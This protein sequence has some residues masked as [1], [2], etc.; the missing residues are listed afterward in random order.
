MAADPLL[1]AGEPPRIWTEPVSGPSDGTLA[2]RSRR[3]EAAAPIAPDA[4]S[5]VRVTVLEFVDGVRDLVV[6]ARADMVGR[7]RLDRIA[8]VLSGGVAPSDAVSEQPRDRLAKAPA[9]HGEWS[10]LALVPDAPGPW[11]A[12]DLAAALTLVLARTLRDGLTDVDESTT[13]A[14]FRALH[15]G[16]AQDGGEIADRATVALLVDPDLPPASLLHHRPAL[17]ADHPFTL[18]AQPDGDGAYSLRLW[19]RAGDLSRAERLASLLTSALRALTEPDQERSLGTVELLDGA[20]AS[21]VLALGGT[22]P[23]RPADRLAIPELVRARALQS[24]DAIAVVDRSA[25][26]TYRELVDRADELALGLDR[27]GVRPGDRVGVCL[28]RSAELVVALLAVMTAGAAYVPLDPAH[29]AERLAFT[30]RDAGLDVVLTDGAAGDEALASCTAV[31]PGGL[32]AEGGNAAREEAQTAAVAP[33]GEPR[34][35]PSADDPAYVIYTSGSTGRPKGVVVPHRNVVAL[36]NATTDSFALGP[37]DV[38]TWFH[39]AAFDF[40]VWEI[41]GALTTGGR[42]VVVPYWTCR[43]P[44]DFRD[45]LARER[46]TVLN[47]TPSSFAG[48]VGLEEGRRPALD[49]LRLVILGG[50]P[51]DTGRLLP[52]FDA[53]P[54]SECRVVNMFGITETTVHVTGGTVTRQ[55][56]LSGDRSVGRPLPGWSV[57]ILDAS[58]R[59]LPPG[60]AGEIAVSGE[61]LALGY[62]NRP[63]LTAERFVTDPRDGTRLYLSGD[64]GLLRPDG[65]LEHHGRIDSQVQLRGHRIELDEIRHVLLGHED[66]REAVVRVV[67]PEDDADAA[68][69]EAY[70]VLDKGDPRRIRRHAARRLPE[71]MVPLVFDVPRIPL[72]VNGKTDVRRLTDM[73]AQAMADLRSEVGAAAPD[74]QDEDV[75][76][77]GANGGTE[78]LVLASWREVLA[79]GAEPDEDFFDLGGNSLLAL[80]V[81]HALRDKGLTVTVKDVYQ[82]RTAT[83]LAARIT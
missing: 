66:V 54:E 46:V 17:S 74:I 69:I 29:P 34:T 1:F 28:E 51:L 79:P 41:W 3:R 43:S 37:D 39:S 6:T 20:A 15:A 22:R 55:Q 61:G 64:V 16:E 38:W 18:H 67:R 10:D 26:L 68:R 78:E 70:V 81:C 76:L 40:S 83:A 35:V 57:R 72:T 44:E 25:G 13:V 50:E 60:S 48:L 53:Y 14:R 32:L 42:L 4:R 80:R 11:T 45:L 24:P 82:C 12:G 19:Y 27:L 73:A 8:T 52:W 30:V 47:Q 9:V 33:F 77:P 5:A 49:C 21:R 31:S 58:G 63:E 75:P 59:L 62:L 65:Q 71:Y 56:A 2:D 7:R 23:D 36:L